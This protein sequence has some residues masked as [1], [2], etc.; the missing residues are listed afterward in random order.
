MI[1]TVIFQTNIL[2]IVGF[3]VRHSAYI[4]LCT[5]QREE[6]FLFFLLFSLEKYFLLMNPKY[7]VCILLAEKG[8]SFSTLISTAVNQVS[9]NYFALCTKLY[10]PSTL[11]NYLIFC[12]N[13][14]KTKYRWIGRENSNWSGIW[15]VK[16]HCNLKKGTFP[17]DF[18]NNLTLIVSVRTQ[19]KVL[20][21][22]RVAE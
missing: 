9:G 4:S 13:F 1:T 16:Y 5:V 12:T 21:R 19:N 20:T 11:N 10:I 6:L 15:S 7:V 3:Y 17:Y 8:S 18:G 14:S 2:R 22:L